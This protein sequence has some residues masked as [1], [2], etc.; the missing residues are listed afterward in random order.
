MEV[1]RVLIF[2]R[3][4]M[5]LGAPAPHREASSNSMCVFPRCLLPFLFGEFIS[6]YIMGFPHMTGHPLLFVFKIFKLKLKC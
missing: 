2:L 6:C 3:L 1:M 5:A 4:V